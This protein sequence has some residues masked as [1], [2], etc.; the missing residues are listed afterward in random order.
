MEP[1]LPRTGAGAMRRTPIRQPGAAKAESVPIQGRLFDEPLLSRSA[2]HRWS[3][4][5]QGFRQTESSFLVF[6]YDGEPCSSRPITGRRSTPARGRPDHC[7][8][9][10][11]RPLRRR[12][13]GELVAHQHTCTA[14]GGCADLFGGRSNAF[15]LLSKTSVNYVNPGA[16]N[17]PDRP[18]MF[19]GSIWKVIVDLGVERLASDESGVYGRAY[20]VDGSS[21]LRGVIFPERQLPADRPRS[22]H[23]VPA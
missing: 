13:D 23:G 7:R 22:G 10:R 4:K 1:P 2:I 21:T 14:F 5:K 17:L 9:R 8:A 16:S 3:V 20:P 18:E 19:P 11:L 15:D 6:L 12:L